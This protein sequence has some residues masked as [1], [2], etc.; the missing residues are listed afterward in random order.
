MTSLQQ[1]FATIFRTSQAGT[2][3]QTEKLRI[4]G[5]IFNLWFDIS[6]IDHH[7]TFSHNRLVASIYIWK[8]QSADSMNKNSSTHRY[9]EM[10][11]A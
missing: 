7:V 10:R 2:E 6:D 5:V 4:V 1:G 3:T 11:H 9:F 8:H